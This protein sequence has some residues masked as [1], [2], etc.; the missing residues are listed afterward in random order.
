MD[1]RKFRIDTN[2]SILGTLYRIVTRT[3]AE[4]AEL[5]DCDGYTD[6]HNKQIVLRQET[7]TFDRLAYLK[8]IIRHEI[9]HAFFYESG[10][11][12]NWE[13]KNYGQEETVVDWIA[14][15]HNKMHDAFVT[16]YEGILE[17][18]VDESNRPR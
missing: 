10:L 12:E 4:I 3:E 16:A 6:Y 2:I 14:I 1:T 11:A 9:V 8:K 13:H 5:K 7:D 18:S 15:Q 17:V